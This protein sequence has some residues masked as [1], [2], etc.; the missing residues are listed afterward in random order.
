MRKIENPLALLRFIL[1]KTQAQLARELGVTEGY[2]EKIER[3]EKEMTSR[4]SRMIHRLYGF[5]S[6]SFNRPL[7]DPTDAVWMGREIG[8]QWAIFANWNRS[9]QIS[10]ADAP[11]AFLQIFTPPILELI[12]KAQLKSVARALMLSLEDWMHESARHFRLGTIG[13]VYSTK[14]GQVKHSKGR[15]IEKSKGGSGSPGGWVLHIPPPMP[16]APAHI[17]K[18][19]EPW[20]KT[21]SPEQVKQWAGIVWP[22]SPVLAVGPAV[23][24]KAKGKTGTRRA[25]RKPRRV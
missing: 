4:L 1:A 21:L 15:S 13:Q 23:K 2:I 24:A 16:L 10:N 20:R 18:A 12:K 19:C 6:G 8:N 17:R 7:P 3:G 14:W 9:V 5:E 11:E 25:S 22:E